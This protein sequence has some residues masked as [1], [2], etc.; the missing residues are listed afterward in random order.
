MNSIK[1]LIL[2]GLTPHTCTEY[3][4]GYG[5]NNKHTGCFEL[6]SDVFIEATRLTPKRYDGTPQAPD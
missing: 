4:C 3:S 6:S 1:R 2:T 5:H